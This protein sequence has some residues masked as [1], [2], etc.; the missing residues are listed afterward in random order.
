MNKEDLVPTMVDKPNKTKLLLTKN[1][2]LDVHESF[3]LAVNKL[4]TN[5]TQNIFLFSNKQT[6]NK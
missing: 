1:I 3:Y 2:E 6:N 5:E 4:I